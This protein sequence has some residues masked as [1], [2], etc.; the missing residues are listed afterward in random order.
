MSSLQPVKVSLVVAI[1]QRVLSCERRIT[2]NGSEA[3]VLA[4]EHF[5]E[6]DL[7]VKWRLRKL[8]AS[9]RLNCIGWKRCDIKF[10]QRFRESPK[11]VVPILTAS[12]IFVGREE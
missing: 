2:N 5:R 1:N 9:Q 8:P 12:A 4:V 11:K 7:S 10:V 6:L 3:G